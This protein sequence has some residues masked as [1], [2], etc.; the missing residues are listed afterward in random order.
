MRLFPVS[1]P[2]KNS[3]VVSHSNHL[4]EARYYLTLAEQR[5]I[6]TLLSFISPDDEDFKD[7]E[8]KISEFKKIIG[9][10]SNAIYSNIRPILKKIQGRVI[11]IPKTNEIMGWFSY[12]KYIE[13]TGSIIIRFDKALKPH[14]LNLKKQFTQYKILIIAQFQSYYT[15]RIY[16]LLKQYETIGYREIEVLELK[17]MLDIKEEKYSL[18]YD[19]RKRVINQA[20]KEFEAKDKETGC[21]KSDI[22]FDLETIK[23]GRRITHLRFIIKKQKVH[24]NRKNPADILI[25]S[26][27]KE[28]DSPAQEALAYYGITGSTAKKYLAEQTEDEILQ[29]VYLL[30]LRKNNKDKAPIS[31]IK[32]YL[33]KLLNEHAGKKSP[34]EL[35]AE[36][37]AKRKEA[38]RKEQQRKEREE[39]KREACL[40]K[41]ESEIKRAFLA[42]LNE[43]EK[44]QILN[45]IKAEY[46]AISRAITSLENGAGLAFL[47]DHIPDYETKKQAC[48]ARYLAN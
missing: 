30:E 18:F 17:K 42:T 21:Y 47:S 19:F 36:E 25:D 46:P 44:D 35:E 13:E 22:T 27:K 15:I 2:K 28:A 48:L 8:I 37:E 38:L 3:P 4:T 40:K 34:A 29:T 12:S 32:S 41:C 24:S 10:N 14:L 11:E 9:V 6:I 7:Y 16:T 23:T 45:K 20:K 43:A 33:V 5:L 1:L 31:N 26:P 39:K